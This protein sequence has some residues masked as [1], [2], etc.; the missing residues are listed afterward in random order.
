MKSDATV[1]IGGLREIAS[2]YDG[3]LVGLWGTVHNG[4]APLPGAPECLAA[5]KRAGKRVC[6]LSNAP[7]RVRSVTARLDEMGIPRSSYDHAMSSGEATHLALRDR[8][9]PWHAA[10]GNRCFHLGPPRASGRAHVWTPVTNAHLVCRYL[11]E[12]T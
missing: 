10:L 9:D 6:L 5:L 8:S 3:Y 11:L 4:V 2:A 1:R 12:K 7:R